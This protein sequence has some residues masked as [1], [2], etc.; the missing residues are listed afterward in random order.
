MGPATCPY[1][2]SSLTISLA[3]FTGA[4]VAT[5]PGNPKF[6]VAVSTIAGFGVGGVLVPPATIAITACADHLIATTIALSLSI[7]V[8]GG[9][10]GY[11]IYFNIFSQKLAK[12]LPEYIAKAAVEAGLPV[13]NV[14]NFVGTFIEAPTA[15]A[16]VPGITPEIIAAASLGS[17]EAYAYALT[18]VW[19]TSIAFGV[20]SIVAACLLGNNQAFLTNRIAAKIRS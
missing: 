11:T 10:I 6:A 15:L 20:I 8:L 3:A 5:N 12:A 7:R 18:F 1:T 14:E 19:Y 9:S 2:Y 17:Q 4:L 16:N 13:T